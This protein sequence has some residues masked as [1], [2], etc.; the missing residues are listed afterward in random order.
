M[1]TSGSQQGS[2]GGSLDTSAL[3]A[4]LRERLAAPD[5]DLGG[6]PFSVELLP[7]GYS[8]LT[9]RVRL[10]TRDLILRRPPIGANVPAGHDMSREYR[11]LAALAPVYARVPQPLVYCN[12]PA[13]FGAPFYLMERVDGVVLRRPLPEGLDLSPEAMRGVSEA[14]IDNL[15]AIHALD[16]TTGALSQL[17]HP[18]GYL[19]RQVAGWIQ[20][21]ARARTDDIP[22]VERVQAWLVE[23]MPQQ[24]YAA[25][26]HN[27]YKYDNLIFNP[28]DLTDIRAVLDWEMATLGDPLSDLG[29]TLAY[30]LDADDPP[31]RL[32]IPLSDNLTT[33]PGNLHRAELAQRYAQGSSR[34][35]TDLIYYFVYGL[36]K[37]A[38]IGQQIHARYVAGLL[39]DPRFGRFQPSI[40]A[41][42]ATAARAIDTGRIDR[43]A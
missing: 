38:V 7:F 42:V 32:N 1:S 28:A 12:D 11:V 15:A 39:P 6:Q 23:R 35:L 2:R 22:D 8:N 36:F 10:G 29:T 26:I 9:Y 24:R 25:L 27:D 17:G 43:L 13:V 33:L 30:W 41:A 31:D 40:L 5:E 21:Y 3:E 34:D 4:Y 14:F 16:A 19:Q 20:R 18:D 37:N